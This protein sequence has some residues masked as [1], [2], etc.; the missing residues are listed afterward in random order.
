MTVIVFGTYV[1]TCVLRYNITIWLNLNLHWAEKNW[2]NA[3]RM[4][5][6]GLSVHI[7]KF[8]SHG[9]HGAPLRLT[10]PSRMRFFMPREKRRRICFAAVRC[11]IVM[12][13]FLAGWL[14]GQ[15]KHNAPYSISRL[16]SWLMQQF[17]SFVWWCIIKRGAGSMVCGR[18]S[19]R[20]SEGTVSWDPS[21]K[22]WT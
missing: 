7:L 4:Q 8:A 6:T 18:L 12:R 1:F 13:R 21:L 16:C 15:T 22:I 20:L 5:S 11:K 9:M 14:M 2:Q 10:C 19:H 17:Y 3:K